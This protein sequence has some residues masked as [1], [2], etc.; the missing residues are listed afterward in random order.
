MR[1]KDKGIYD[2]LYFVDIGGYFGNIN[3]P[4]LGC[5]VRGASRKV[6]ETGELGEK[7]SVMSNPS[8]GF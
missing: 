1:S 5:G 2:N 8:L 4:L 7:V 6:C 3:F